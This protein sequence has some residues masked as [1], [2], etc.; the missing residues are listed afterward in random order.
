MGRKFSI[1][2]KTLKA[3]LDITKLA[4]FGL[5]GMLTFLLLWQGVQ[6]KPLFILTFIWCFLLSDLFQYISVLLYKILI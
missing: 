5:F 1:P 4:H 2:E 3:T 6:P